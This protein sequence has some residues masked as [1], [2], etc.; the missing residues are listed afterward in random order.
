MSPNKTKAIEAWKTPSCKTDMQSFLGHVNYHRRFVKSCSRIAKPFSE[1]TKNVP[2]ILNNEATEA[3]EKRVR[4][5]TSAPV[6]RQFD[7]HRKFHVTT[8]ACRVGIGAVME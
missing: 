1:H 2:F 4:A 7:S 5:I 3:F 6:L 8:D